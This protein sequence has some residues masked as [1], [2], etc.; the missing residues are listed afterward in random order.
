MGTGKTR[1]PNLWAHFPGVTSDSCFSTATFYP[2]WNH[3]LTLALDSYLYPLSP[4]N[5]HWSESGD[6]FNFCVARKQRQ[7]VSAHT[8]AIFDESSAMQA[9]CGFKISLFVLFTLLNF[10]LFLQNFLEN[11]IFDIITP[12]KSMP[13]QRKP[14][15]CVCCRLCCYFWSQISDKIWQ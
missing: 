8:P 2:Q 13:R 7:H 3:A 10:D 11:N 6:F 9:R 14:L 1:W 5:P 15:C 4:I 12:Y